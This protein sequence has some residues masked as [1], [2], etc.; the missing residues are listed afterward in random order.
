MRR[1]GTF[2]YAFAFKKADGSAKDL[3]G[4]SIRAQYSRRAGD[5]AREDLGASI[6]VAGDGT[7]Q[8]L[9]TDEQTALRTIGTTYGWDL[10]LVTPDGRV[11]GP[12]LAG[13]L[14]IEDTFTQGVS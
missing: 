1:G 10:L 12:Y 9:L 8:L 7:A 3:T 4:Y 13:R 5:S 14:Q 2:F 6:V 11:L